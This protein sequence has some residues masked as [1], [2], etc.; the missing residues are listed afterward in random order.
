MDAEKSH[1][2]PSASWRPGKAG[3]VVQSKSE[4]LRTRG[5]QRCKPQ[6]EFEGLMS[7]GRR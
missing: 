3:G 6:P 1:N 4:G 2:L 5:G 7:K